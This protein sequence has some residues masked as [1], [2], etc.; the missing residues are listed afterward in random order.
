MIFIVGRYNELCNRLFTFSNIIA[1]AKE[2]NHRVINIAFGEEYRKWFRST[3]KDPLCRFPPVETSTVIWR[4]TIPYVFRLA[5]LM[6]KL[7][8]KY[9]I[10]PSIRIGGQGVFFFNDTEV[11]N[12]VTKIHLSKMS[13]FDGLYFIDRE[14]FI[15]HADFIRD[16][17]IPIKEIEC[18]VEKFISDIRNNHD[19]IIGVHI[20]HGD[21]EQFCNGLFYYTA[22]EY[23]SVMSQ[24]LELFPEKKVAFLI[25]SNAHQDSSVFKNLPFFIGPGH[26]VEDLYA[27]ASCDYIIGPPSTYTQWASF[28]GQVPRYVINYKCEKFNGIASREPQISDFNVL[29]CGFGKYE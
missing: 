23:C 21:Y 11:L 7:F 27:L 9:K 10:F 25:C 1:F 4:K 13:F 22:E 3:E 19:I 24:I 12:I 15:K 14:N 28:Y 26:Y 8:H 18:K 2:Y 20:R 6:A 17:F 29:L 5:T 16:F